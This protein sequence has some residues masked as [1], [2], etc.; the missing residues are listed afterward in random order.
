MTAHLD[1]DIVARNHVLRRNFIDGDPQI[2]AH[3]LLHE[4]HQ[5]KQAGAFRPSIAA[6]GEDD[7]ALVFAQDADGSIDEDQG[8]YGDD[9][10]G[11]Q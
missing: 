10:N 11:D 6:E 1:R 9:N 4:G 5:Q 7:A 8:Q 2:D 3:H